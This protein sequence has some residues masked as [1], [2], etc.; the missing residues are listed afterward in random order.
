VRPWEAQIDQLTTQ[1]I[2][3]DDPATRKEI[4]AKIQDLWARELP[5]IPIIAINIVPGWSNRIGNVR[6][7]ILTHHVIWNADELTKNPRTAARQ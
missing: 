1:L 7:S 3:S 4:F 6:P 5:A 2:R